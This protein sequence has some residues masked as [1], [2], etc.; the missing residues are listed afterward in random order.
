MAAKLSLL[1]RLLPDL[2]NSNSSKLANLLRLAVD[3][4][5]VAGKLLL[6]REALPAANVSQ[7]VSGNPSLL[8]MSP[9]QLRINL[10]QVQIL[11]GEGSGRPSTQ[12]QPLLEQAPH[13]ID[14]TQLKE[15][16]SEIGRL[17][18]GVGGS[19]AELLVARPDLALECQGLVRV[20]NNDYE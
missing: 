3:V 4:E 16:L 2:A 15:T 19:P 13:L 17:F 12:W 1:H 18:A 5:A 8:S 6:L 11:L 7:I 10:Q 9:E 14:A 20:P